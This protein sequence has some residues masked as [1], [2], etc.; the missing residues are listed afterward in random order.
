MSNFINF[1]GSDS[2]Q[3]SEG[4]EMIE[5]KNEI[6]RN[7]NQYDNVVETIEKS[8]TEHETTDEEQR[9]LM[10]EKVCCWPLRC[11]DEQKC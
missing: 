9:K 4:L 3:R 8:P 6:P 11:I 10:L 7:N 5:V 2:S 1:G